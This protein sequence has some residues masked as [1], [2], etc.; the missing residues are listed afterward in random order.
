MDNN[1]FIT[2]SFLSVETGAT[3]PSPYLL[4]PVFLFP[5]PGW[6]SASA[7]PAVLISDCQDSAELA[8]FDPADSDLV[9]RCF[10]AGHY[11]DPADP[12]S[13]PGSA[14]HHS[15]SGPGFGPDSDLVVAAVALSLP[16]KIRTL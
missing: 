15:D 3:Q 11:S 9:D 4:Y 8:D 16:S 5:L 2:N 14:D 7:E 10:A 6:L 12:G 1:L 13:G